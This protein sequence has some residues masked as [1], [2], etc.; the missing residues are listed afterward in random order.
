MARKYLKFDLNCFV[1][2]NKSIK[3]CP[4]PACQRA[5]NLP[6]S[7]RQVSILKSRFCVRTT[8]F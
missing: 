5:V 3:W 4:Y 8:I 6:E 2:T 1:E 7:E